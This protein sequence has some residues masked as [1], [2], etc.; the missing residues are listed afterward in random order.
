MPMSLVP[1][2]HRRMVTLFACGL[3]LVPAAC[4]N[5]GK[6]HGQEHITYR[7]TVLGHG[8]QLSVSETYLVDT[9]PTGFV[10][11]PA[12]PRNENRRD[13]MHIS[14]RLLARRPEA[15][16]YRVHYL[17]PWRLLWY[18]VIE[19]EG[20]SSGSQW[21]LVAFERVGDHW[22]EYQENKLSELEPDELWEIAQ[23][24]RYLP[25]N[26][27]QALPTKRGATPGPPLP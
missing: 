17:S 16:G 12:S 25:S 4:D 9:T 1:T 22:L 8:L 14:I 26:R 15:T 20:G 24:V 5:S 11:A 23:G 27:D 21:S 10:L 3:W 13:P 18:T 6:P 19:E 2:A 7:R